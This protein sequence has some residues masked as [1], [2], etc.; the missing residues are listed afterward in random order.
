MFCVIFCEIVS[1]FCEVENLALPRKNGNQR[2]LMRH[3]NATQC[4]YYAS[5]PP[6]ITHHAKLRGSSARRY[7]IAVRNQMNNGPCA[8]IL[9][10]PS[11]DGFHDELLTSA[12]AKDRSRAVSKLDPT[13]VRITGN[14]IQKQQRHLNFT[15]RTA[16]F[17]HRAFVRVPNDPSD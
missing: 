5:V 16:Y 3:A 8:L 2:R 12:I 13:T 4:I 6:K 7:Y 1:F 15:T 14:T 11:S 10:R 17:S 9:D